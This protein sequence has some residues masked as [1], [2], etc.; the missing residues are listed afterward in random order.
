[1]VARRPPLPRHY[2]QILQSPGV[3]EQGSLGASSSHP[4]TGQ[5]SHLQNELNRNSFS[6]FKHKL[7]ERIQSLAFMIYT[8]GWNNL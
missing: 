2:L 5:H 7:W 3:P 6:A 1:M 4:C 8:Q